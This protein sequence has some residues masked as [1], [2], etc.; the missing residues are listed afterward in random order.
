MNDR[1]I[2]DAAIEGAR[3]RLFDRLISLGITSPAV[4]YPAHDTVEEGK[5]LRGGRVGA[6]TKNLLL[7]DKKGRLFLFSIHENRT[8]DLKTLHQRVGAHGR[9]GFAS[10]ERM[11]ELLGVQPGA[12]TPLG[13]I[14]DTGGA[15]TAVVDASLLGAEQ[16]NFHPLV[17][18]E[19]IGLR[20]ADLLAFIRSCGREPLLLDFDSGDCS[21]MSAPLFPA[22]SMPDRDWWSVLWP[23]PADVLRKLGIDPDMTVLDLCCGDGYFTAPLARAVNGKV[24]ALDL[25]PAMIGKAQTEVARQ[26]AQVLAWLCAD[27]RDV[28]SFVPQ[29]VDYVLMANTFHGVPDQRALSRAVRSVLRRGG[30]FGI[31]NWYP[32]P[33]EQT[34]V[35]GQHRG[36]RTDMRMPPAA[37][38]AIVEP[39]GFAALQIVELPPYH[40]ATVFETTF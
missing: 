20:P 28:A 8:L 25:D 15:V 16:V 11:A 10:A 24:Y 21:M 13:L 33:R 38:S 29:P 26:G 32:L 37:V 30:L 31:V 2:G 35:S 9:L 5:R 36:P 40:Y 19:S 6:F 17:N 18:T 22:T 14:N 7:R 3:T 12:L 34:S 23:D 4:P 39:E 1:S 27:A